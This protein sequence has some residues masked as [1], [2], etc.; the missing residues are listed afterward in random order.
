M[1]LGISCLYMGVH[2]FCM[3][4]KVF[5]CSRQEL[6]KRDKPPIKFKLRSGPV[7]T[8]LIA[9]TWHVR[10]DICNKSPTIGLR[11]FCDILWQNAERLW[12]TWTPCR[13][14]KI[15]VHPY[16]NMIYQVPQFFWGL[17][18]RI[19]RH[20]PDL[21][22]RITHSPLRLYSTNSYYGRIPWSNTWDM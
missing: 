9:T 10:M 3:A 11:I 1:E 21:Y 12:C 17:C 4:G 6:R 16:I 2:L 20:E 5:K 22:I 14:Y 18:T 19:W 7:C 8:C 15:N 13:P